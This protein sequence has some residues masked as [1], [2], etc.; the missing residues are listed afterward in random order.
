MTEDLDAAGEEIRK[1]L[2]D[3]EPP[4]RPKG[5][6]NDLTGEAKKFFLGLI[7]HFVMDSDLSPAFHELFGDQDLPEDEFR[8]MVILM[9]DLGYLHIEVTEDRSRYRWMMWRGREYQPV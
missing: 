5:R 3:D 8:D 6:V 1:F 4:P 2:G 7:D 9:V